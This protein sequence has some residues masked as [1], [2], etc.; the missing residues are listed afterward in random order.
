MPKQQPD[1]VLLLALQ[2]RVVFLKKQL[3][4]TLEQHEALAKEIK[5]AQGSLIKIGDMEYTWKES[6]WLVRTED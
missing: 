2:R 5:R 1:F 3:Q 6:H 4:E